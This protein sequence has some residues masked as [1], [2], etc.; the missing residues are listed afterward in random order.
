MG[1]RSLTRGQSLDVQLEKLQSCDKVFNEKRSGVDAGRP[2]LKQ[3]REFVKD[4]D[5]LLMTKIDR[6]ARSTSALYRF[7]CRGE[8]PFHTPGGVACA[9]Q[10]IHSRRGGKGS[11]LLSRIIVVANAAKCQRLRFRL[12]LRHG[13]CLR[14]GCA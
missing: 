12:H 4:G 11:A 10:P 7:G 1:P 3:C 8:Q 9:G 13:F 2:A 5:T 6:L 14:L